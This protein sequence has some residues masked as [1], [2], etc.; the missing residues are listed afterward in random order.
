MDETATNYDDKA[1]EDDGSCEYDAPST[2]LSGDITED[3]VLDAQYEYTIAGG[4][5]VKDGVTLTIPAGTVIKSNPDESV[6][7][8]FD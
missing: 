8:L 4:V 7:Y 3:R 6:A 2:T 1:K 5:H